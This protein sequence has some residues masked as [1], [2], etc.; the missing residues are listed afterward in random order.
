MK[1]IVLTSAMVLGVITCA[2]SQVKLE[3]KPEKN[4]QDKW[5][6]ESF[7]RYEIFKDWDN[8]D[9]IEISGIRSII[10]SA[11]P[12]ADLDSLKIGLNGRDL[13]FNNSPH[14]NMPILKPDVNDPMPSL[15]P[16]STIN[17][18]LRIRKVE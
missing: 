8:P 17:Y 11:E 10:G 6:S 16:D 1:R 2:F 3:V 4:A 18:T 14:D 5:G 13:V 12:Q 15:T 7:N 9:D